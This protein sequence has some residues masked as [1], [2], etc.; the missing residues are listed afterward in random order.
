MST[1]QLSIS[2]SYRGELLLTSD[3]VDKLNQ[4]LLDSGYKFEVVLEVYSAPKVVV[5]KAKSSELNNLKL[6]SIVDEYLPSRSAKKR[7]YS[8]TDSMSRY[9]SFGA[10]STENFEKRSSRPRKQTLT[11][12]EEFYDEPSNYGHSDHYHRPERSKSMKAPSSKPPHKETK[13]VKILYRTVPI[14]TKHLPKLPKN[15]WEY[16]C[17]RILQTIKYMDTDKWFW[18][19]V[20]PVVDG[21]PDYLDIIKRPMDFHTITER[22]HT[23]H[24]SSPYGWQT[25]MRQIFYN[26][27]LF[28]QRENII[29]QAA[30]NLSAALE[31]KLKS[32]K[33]INPD[34]FYETLSMD[35]AKLRE[36]IESLHAPR[37]RKVYDT[38][39][40]QIANVD[41]VRAKRRFG[42]P[43]RLDDENFV[44]LDSGSSSEISDDDEYVNLNTKYSAK[45]AMRPDRGLR[46]ERVRGEATV[47]RRKQ[48]KF[49]GKTFFSEDLPEYGFVP[50]PP[51]I[52]KMLNDK[53]LTVTQQKTLQANMVRLAPNQRKAALELV[54]DELGILA[55]SHK[56]DPHFFFDTDL[57]S[58]ERQKQFFTYVSQMAKTNIEHMLKNEKAKVAKQPVELRMLNV[59]ESFRTTSGMF[60]ESS[61]TS[62]IS[63][64]ASNLLSS[65]EFFS[66]SGS[67]NDIVP[68]KPVRTDTPKDVGLPEY[69]PVDEMDSDKSHLSEGIMG[70]HAD[71]L[72]KIDT[73][74]ESDT[75]SNPGKKTAWMDWKG[76]AI[77]HRDV[78]QQTAV[79]PR[80][81]DEQIAESFDAR[82]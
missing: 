59:S 35:P 6:H 79:P 23:N 20:D 73:P 58:I 81:E 63:D 27:F 14:S 1:E 68:E 9:D 26:A 7:A 66:S 32:S 37:G 52:Q 11:F 4:D 47:R 25:D 18:Y 19:P 30:N 17:Y 16:S 44:D 12:L 76:Q 34:E 80:N 65:D 24:Y 39:A 82:I 51:T 13:P 69:L 71:F 3:E 60:S 74:S 10:S 5:K 8:P 41:E 55:D 64:V 21:V 48:T 54:Q 75:V 15:T 42:R 2:P 78:A 56:D 72:G 22:L 38:W 49:G 33:Y 62:S 57:L 45:R 43:A 53:P 31:S 61:S 40:T 67:E 36:E 28:Y 77:H 50:Q 70:N 29:W 46:Q